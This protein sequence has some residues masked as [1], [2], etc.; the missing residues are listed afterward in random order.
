[1]INKGHTLLF[2]LFVYGLSFLSYYGCCTKM[3]YLNDLKIAALLHDIGKIDNEVQFVRKKFSNQGW[4][5]ERYLKLLGYSSSKVF[6]LIRTHHMRK[7]GDSYLRASDNASAKERNYGGNHNKHLLYLPIIDTIISYQLEMFFNRDLWTPEDLKM[8]IMRCQWLDIVP[9][10][11]NASLESQSLRNHLVQTCQYVESLWYDV[12]VENLFTLSCDRK[13]V[14]QL[15]DKAIEGNPTDL[16]VDAGVSEPNGDLNPK[17][18]LGLSR[19][20]TQ[21]TLK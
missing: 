15:M 3:T 6:K 11:L 4:T 10:D 17:V 14:Y 9:A 1:M 2:L 8:Y 5:S 12:P 19:R 16:F 21:L 20:K 7:Q 18:A 13:A